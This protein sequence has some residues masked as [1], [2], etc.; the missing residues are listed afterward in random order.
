VFSSAAKREH[1]DG[2]KSENT[3][4][5]LKKKA[6]KEK[7]A[8]KEKKMHKR[9]IKL[10]NQVL[11]QI[12]VSKEDQKRIHAMQ[13][14]YRKRMLVNREKMGQARKALGQL[15]QQKASPAEIEL[16]I[17]KVTKLFGDQLR[18]IVKNRRAMEKILGEEK[19]RQ[20][21]KQARKQ[22]RKHAGRRGADN[23]MQRR[24]Q[25]KGGQ[26]DRRG[27]RHGEGRPDQPKG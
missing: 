10:M 7:S 18:M 11:N 25:R 19:Y 2:V 26:S 22:M 23:N 9:K 14:K 12:G 24:G 27:G 4:K 16:A 1:A 15:Q 6:K 17:Q 21:M 8:I 5:Q 20:F 3:E 13:E